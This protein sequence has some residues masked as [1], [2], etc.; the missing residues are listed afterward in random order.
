MPQDVLASLLGMQARQ[1]IGVEADRIA[2]KREMKRNLELQA[3]NPRTF[4]AGAVPSDVS[5]VQEDINLDPDT[6]DYADTEAAYARP[7]AAARRDTA[8]QDALAKLLMPEQMK[9]QNALALEKM[10]GQNDLATARAKGEASGSLL[11][12]LT[13]AAL[14]Q[15]AEAYHTSRV[16]PTGLTRTPQEIGAILNRSAEIHPGADVALNAAN[17]R[18]NANSLSKLQGTTDVVQAFT[19]TADLNA[20]RLRQMIAKAPGVGVPF[21]DQF[22]RPAA[23]AMGD[24]TMAGLDAIRE[25]VKNEYARILNT[26]NLGGVVTQGEKEALDKVLAPS[27]SPEQMLEALDQLKI[28]A[29]NRQESYNRRIGAVRDRMSVQPASA[30]PRNPQDLGSNWG[31][32]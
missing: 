17:Y 27:G 19:E 23:K 20:D 10:R 13:P 32:R 14:D 6:G 22:I 8:R 28:E 25:S 24:T 21:F 2:R 29:Q 5:N 4:M 30:A 3:A 26:A 12:F 9:G 31:A 1:G 15:E 11:D 16:L 18:A 7:E